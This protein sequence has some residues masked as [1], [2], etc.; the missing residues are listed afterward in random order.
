MVDVWESEA[1]L[2]QFAEVL[3]PVL[4]AAGFPDAPPQIFPAYNFIKS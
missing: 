1:K 4:K 3:M 2:M